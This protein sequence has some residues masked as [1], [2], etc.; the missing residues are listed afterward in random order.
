ME[1]ILITVLSSRIKKNLYL[2]EK[3]Y[4]APAARH[5]VWRLFLLTQSSSV[6]YLQKSNGIKEVAYAIINDKKL[7]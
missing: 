6:K 3:I 4:L 5:N 2:F 7:E 1:I